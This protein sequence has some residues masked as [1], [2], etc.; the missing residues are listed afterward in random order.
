M[1]NRA[2]QAALYL[3]FMLAYRF[4]FMDPPVSAL[5]MFTQFLANSFS[6]PA[7]VKNYMSENWLLLYGGSISTFQAY[8]LGMMSKA[9][10]EKASHVPARAPPISP[11]DINI[12]CAYIDQNPPQ[13]PAVKS[14]I[15]LAFATFLRVSNVLSPTRNTSRG[16]HTLLARDVQFD[17]YKL[18]VNVRSTK[19]RRT[20]KHQT[21]YVLPST[22]QDVC[23]VRAWLCYK[24]A[25]N[26]CPLGPAF[27]VDH[28]LPLTPGPVVSIMRSALSEAG[29]QFYK[30]VSFHS[31]RRGGAQTAAAHRATSQDLMR[32]G[33]WTS[34]AG[35]Q[36]YLKPTPSMVPTILAKTLAH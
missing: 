7:T 17:G 29:K 27:M 15:L 3:K 9:V 30:E 14:A 20:G 11:E 13:H 6:S 16:Q 22:S 36:T 25:L 2:A 26:P 19:T 12:I 1:K 24:T 18:S 28:S 5:A 35:L 4:N 23:P 8:E 33:T 10:V 31:L 34:K 21:L 32:H